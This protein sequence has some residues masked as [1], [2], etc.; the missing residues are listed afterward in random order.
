MPQKLDKVKIA[1]A[2]RLAVREAVKVLQWIICICLLLFVCSFACM[3]S[4][5]TLMTCPE[6]NS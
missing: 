3:P 2:R 5:N 6:G 4:L 1:S